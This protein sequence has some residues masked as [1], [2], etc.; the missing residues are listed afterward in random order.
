MQ[1]AIVLQFG[2]PIICKPAND[3][4]ALV[5]VDRIRNVATK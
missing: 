5:D 4:L 1:Q 3:G 2:R